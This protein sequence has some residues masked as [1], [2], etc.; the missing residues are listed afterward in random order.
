MSGWTLEN[1]VRA[2]CTPIRFDYLQEPGIQFAGVPT[3]VHW[4]ILPLA[5]LIVGVITTDVSPAA[6]I[7]PVTVITPVVAPTVR[8][9]AYFVGTKF[10]PQAVSSATAPFDEIDSVTQVR[11]LLAANIT[12]EA[13]ARFV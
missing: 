4:V 5:E 3:H 7:A 13:F 6:L 12:S 1:R 11:T 10:A 9:V 8:A 2:L